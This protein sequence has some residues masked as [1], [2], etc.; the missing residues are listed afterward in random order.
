IGGH[1][2]V[3]RCEQWCVAAILSSGGCHFADDTTHVQVEGASSLV[4]P[5]WRA[6]AER[7][8]RGACRGDTRGAADHADMGVVPGTLALPYLDHQSIH[9]ARGSGWTR[10]GEWTSGVAAGNRLV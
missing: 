8:C 2:P 9:A 6:G 4:C 1:A 10:R 3:G 5:L 7:R